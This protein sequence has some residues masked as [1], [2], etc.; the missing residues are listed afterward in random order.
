MVKKRKKNRMEGTHI[1]RGWNTIL[2]GVVEIRLNDK[3]TFEH[4]LT[5]VSSKNSC[6]PVIFSHSFGL[7]LSL[8]KHFLQST[9]ALIMWFSGRTSWDY[10]EY[11]VVCLICFYVHRAYWIY[12]ESH[13]DFLIKTSYWLP[14]NYYLLISKWLILLIPGLN[15]WPL[16]SD[17]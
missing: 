1:Q 16:G 2:N 15:C 5:E 4:S 14:R 11:V 13:F 12:F 17:R 6:R 9:L 3:V 10:P 7:D 8:G